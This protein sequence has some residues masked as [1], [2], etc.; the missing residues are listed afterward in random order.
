MNDLILKSNGSVTQS[1]L[2]TAAVRDIH[3]SL[4]GMFRIDVRTPFPDIWKNNPHLFPLDENDPDVLSI[5]CRNPLI[6]RC[7]EL[8]VHS[9]LGYQYYLNEHLHLNIRPTEFK[10]DLY[11]SAEEKAGVS[12]AIAA[13]WDGPYWILNAGCRRK[14]TIKQWNASR[15]QQVINHFRDRIRFIQVG[16]VED[17]H[18][19][20]DGV[21]DLRGK[22]T[23][24]ELICLM[25]HAKG[26]L[27]SSGLLAHLAAAIETNDRR[28]RSCIIIGGGREP[29]HWSAYPG[30]QHVNTIGS[31][32][33]CR[34]GGC[35]RSRT[36]PLGDGEL[37]DQAD[38]M[39][40]S[41]SNSMPR[42]MEM[43]GVQEIILRI[44]Q[45]LQKNATFKDDEE[46]AQILNPSGFKLSPKAVQSDPLTI[47]TALSKLDEFIQRLEPYPGG[48]ANRGIVICAKGVEQFANA[49]VCINMLRNF[50]CR[51]PIQFWYV[52]PNGMDERMRAL[53]K[54]LN[55]ECVDTL[56]ESRHHPTPQAEYWYLKIYASIHSPFNEVLVLDADNVPTIDPE[57]LFHTPQFIE[58]GAIVWPD[59]GHLK[60]D[61]PIWKLCGIQYQDEPEWESGQIVLDKERCWK[62]L[63]LTMWFSEHSDFYYRYMLGGKEMFHM[64]FRK[65]G[66]PMAMPDHPVRS[67]H[68]V[69]CQYDFEG[70]LIFQHG[71]FRKRNLSGVDFHCPGFLYDEERLAFV[72]QFHERWDT[73]NNLINRLDI[74]TKTINELDCVYEI[75]GSTYE[76]ERVGFDQRQMTF[77]LRGC[78]EV[79]GGGCEKYWDIREEQGRMIFEIYNENSITCRLTRHE[80]GHWEGKW[81]YY[82]QM[83]VKL[84]KLS[85]SLE[86]PS[87]PRHI[88]EPL[89]VVRRKQIIFRASLSGYTGYGLHACQIVRDLTKMGYDVQ[90]LANELNEAYAFVPLDV[91]KHIVYQEFANKCEWELALSPPAQFAARNGTKS[92]FFTM[93]ESTRINKESVERMNQAYQII[94]PCHWNAAC[95]SASGVDRPINV[96]PLGIKTEVFNYA[97][98]NLDGICIFGTAGRL[99][100]GGMRKGIEEVILAFQKAFPNAENVRLRIKVFPDCQLPKFSDDRIEVISRY[101]P[102]E[103]L[104]IWFS[105]LTCF[106]SCSRGEGWG[107]M[108]HQSLAIGRP[109]ISAI[110]GGVAEF[111]TEEMGYPVDFRMVPAEGLYKGSG[112][113]IELDQLHIIEQMRRVFRDRCEARDKGLKGSQTVSHLTWS[114]SNALLLNVMKNIGMAAPLSV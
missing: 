71:N 109:L 110:Y 11:L 21:L 31:L 24:R 10:P 73:P 9:I 111:F 54:P 83:P 63:C 114:N 91:R 103:E 87:F 12:P 52:N 50:G 69:L 42:C 65:L 15:Y 80:D 53:V 58:T 68:N 61:A 99:E 32:P 97:P 72:R 13:G 44:D 59:F 14:Q 46:L 19:T 102:E 41:I 70:R 57:L 22:N 34:T 33:C 94:V 77:S 56:K 16:H 101:M 90:I 84:K 105:E 79:G 89:T 100:S 93:W 27:T 49:W 28:L 2:L 3:R 25:Y 20:L 106:V 86:L 40:V 95:L 45:Q 78:I 43:I 113:W 107:L 81:L 6:H 47:S 74:D 82:E 98:M 76:Y 29:A 23:L 30:Q 36:V 104:A 66:Q 17:L 55:V 8:P 96:V 88:D 26:V 108:Q 64:A 92:L 35:W 38:Q 112:L 85:L 39:C 67:P 37:E 75:I 51:L 4:P 18:P 5:E 60:P 7:N 62:A 48:H 1:V